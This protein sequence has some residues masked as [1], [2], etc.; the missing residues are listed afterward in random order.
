MSPTGRETVTNHSSGTVDV[1]VSVRGYYV[2]SIAPSAPGSVS[3]SV[4]GFS[5]TVTWSAPASD[6]GAAITGYQVAAGPDN[7]TVTVGGTATQATLSGLAHASADVFTVA[8]VNAAG[9][10]EIGTWAP[11]A[12]LSG[13]VMSPNGQ[14]VQGATVDLM[15]SDV[16]AS[17]PA[18]WS[19]SIIGTATTDANGIWTFTVPPYSSLPSDAKAAADANGGSLNLDA[20]VGA[21]ATVGTSSYNLEAD[22]GMSAY[23]GTS[24]SP[25][26]PVQVATPESGVPSMTVTP[27][28]AD[29]SSQDTEANEEATS[30][31]QANPTLTDANGNFIGSEMNAY[32]AR[33]TDPYGYV[34]IAGPNH[35]GYSPFVAAGGTNL[36]GVTAT[37]S[38]PANPAVPDC[39]DSHIG[40]NLVYSDTTI[41]KKPRFVVV[42]ELHANWDTTGTFKYET[43]SET[44]VGVGVSADG[45]HFGINGMI[46]FTLEKS[47]EDSLGGGHY[48]SHHVSANLIFYKIKRQGYWVPI[49]DSDTD[50]VNPAIEGNN[51]LAGD[52][53]LCGKPRYFIKEEGLYNPAGS[54]VPYIRN[55][56]RR[57]SSGQCDP[58][59]NTLWS[60][61][62]GWSG[63]KN[64]LPRSKKYRVPYL[65]GSQ[66]HCDSS[67]KGYTYHVGATIGNFNIEAE[68]G[69]K[70]VTTQCIN[71]GNAWP[72]WD[73]IS[74]KSNS[75]HWLW[76][77]NAKI[78]NGPKLFYTY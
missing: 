20:T 71:F 75:T 48:T 52:N 36:S 33:S 76:G 10:S 23:V 54:T 49:S 27:A 16:P 38:P 70:T 37:A 30:G 32:A 2:T 15:P 65:P 18:A 26:G 24:A 42:G 19:P 69:H 40:W 60:L 51:E 13:T 78:I 50:N 77:S 53:I 55:D 39:T 12:V 64:Y 68:T 63:Y 9:T 46:T 41:W 56:C 43:H 29:I 6:G 57:L 3:A 58:N 45:E 25:S 5:A 22:A 4:S 59:D 17:D 67:G 74:Q 31:Y 35:D 34:N 28:Q 1:V 44:S 8:A 21:W 7:A 66:D 62:D 61:T 47:G 14:S 11:P 72:R 73:K